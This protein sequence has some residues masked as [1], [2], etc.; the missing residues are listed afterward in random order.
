MTVIQGF[1]RRLFGIPLDK[2]VRYRD[3]MERLEALD[4]DVAALRKRLNKLQ[5]IVTGG[6]RHEDA[7]EPTIDMRADPRVPL[8]P[9]RN[10]RGF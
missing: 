7:P 4:A 2:P 10:L 5:G 1:F 8:P 9:A 6:M 3:V